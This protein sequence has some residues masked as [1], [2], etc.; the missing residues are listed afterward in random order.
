M[1]RKPRTGPAADPELLILASLASGPNHGYGIMADIETFASDLVTLDNDPHDKRLAWR[2][3]VSHN[4]LDRRLRVA[5]IA[6]WLDRRQPVSSGR[7][8]TLG[9]GSSR[10]SLRTRLKA[11]ISS[12]PLAELL[13]PVEVG[14]ASATNPNPTPML[15][16]LEGSKAP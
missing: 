12:R 15:L 11:R 7:Q 5:E 14:P 1:A 13:P 8:P 3:G 10:P 9:G 6:N 2:H 4:V 16:P